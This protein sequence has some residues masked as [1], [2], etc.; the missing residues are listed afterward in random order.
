MFDR[1]E[2]VVIERLRCCRL[3]LIK[4]SIPVDA[5]AISSTTPPEGAALT[6]EAP[7]MDKLQVQSCHIRKGP[8]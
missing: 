3:A 6:L 2:H 7:G 4:T 8:S 5:L 1:A